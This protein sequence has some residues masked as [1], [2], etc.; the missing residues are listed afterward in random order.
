LSNGD[1]ITVLALSASGLL[2]GLAYGTLFLARWRQRLMLN[3]V[4]LR[5]LDRPN[6]GVEVE[7]IYGL[8]ELWFA[9]IYTLSAQVVLNM[10]TTE[11][12]YWEIP[13]YVLAVPWWLSSM[14][15]LSGLVLFYLGNRWCSPL[16]W[17]GALVSA[18]IWS[19]MFARGLVETGGALGT[20][21][22]YFFG[23]VWQIR[24]MMSAWSRWSMAWHWHVGA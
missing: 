16:R 11:G 24:I 1:L 23:A 15:T 10:T 12:L 9:I 20:L 13:H 19:V 17:L 18:W 7:M 6:G 8:S 4:V 22:F 5:F 21:S 14:A 2:M 3:D